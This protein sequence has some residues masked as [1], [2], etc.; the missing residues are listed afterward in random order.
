MDSYISTIH[1]ISTIHAIENNL[2]IERLQAITTSFSTLNGI[3][4]SIQTENTI[5]W[6]STTSIVSNSN[7]YL[8]NYTN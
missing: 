5:L 2:Y 6:T 3:M 8:F 4:T 1:G 7:Y